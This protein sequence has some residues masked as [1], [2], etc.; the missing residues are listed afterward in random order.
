MTVSHN[1]IE[2]QICTLSA[3]FL[4]QGEGDSFTEDDFSKFLSSFEVPD[5]PFS[6]NPHGADNMLLSSTPAKSL[7]PDRSFPD[8]ES[9]DYVDTNKRQQSVRQTLFTDYSFDEEDYVKFLDGSLMKN[10]YTEEE[11]NS[12][13]QRE[14][15]NSDLDLSAMDDISD[16]DSDSSHSDEDGMDDD[17]G[18]ADPEFFGEIYAL[19]RQRSLTFG[20]SIIHI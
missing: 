7:D 1:H 15:V 6:E 5:S 18:T 17:L 9:L 13:V 10:S 14:E 2:N 19:P 12:F 8:E 16:T 11:W 20:K 3:P 4:L